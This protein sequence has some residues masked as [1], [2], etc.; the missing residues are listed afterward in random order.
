MFHLILVILAITVCYFVGDWRN[1]TK[2]HSTILFYITGDLMYNFL[3]YNKPL[4]QYASHTTWLGHTLSNLLVS[5]TVFPCTILVF[6]RYYPNSGILKK[7]VYISL[8]VAIQSSVEAVSLRLGYFTHHNNWNIVWSIIANFILFPTMVLHQSKP[9][10]AY[11]TYG[12]TAIIM[13][14]IFG[15][16]LSD[17]K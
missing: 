2:Y 1:W 9:L 10:W 11:I 3:A 12:A 8:W 13:L 5:L 4:W 14:L 15:I 6:F 7:I 17:F 16:Q